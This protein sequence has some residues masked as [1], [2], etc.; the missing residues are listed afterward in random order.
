ML[1][2]G[3]CSAGWSTSSATKITSTEQTPLT[4]TPSKHSSR[5][6]SSQWFLGQTS[7][8]TQLATGELSPSRT[9]G[10]SYSFTCCGYK[11]AR[12]GLT[13]WCPWGKH[14]MAECLYLVGLVYASSGSGRKRCTVVQDLPPACQVCA[15]RTGNAQERA[16]CGNISPWYCWTSAPL[17]RKDKSSGCVRESCEHQLWYSNY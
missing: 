6:N 12:L 4:G 17:T 8:K 13:P 9:A 1:H 10:C 7:S 3:Y 11:Q 14:F 15:V 2:T 16:K 5:G